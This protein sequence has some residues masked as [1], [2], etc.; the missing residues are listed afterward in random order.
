MNPRATKAKD[1]RKEFFPLRKK[2]CHGAGGL[3]GGQLGPR[4]AVVIARL[5]LA[6]SC[7]RRA[8]S[9]NPIA[10]SH[11]QEHTPG[12]A[13]TLAEHATKNATNPI[14]TPGLAQKSEP[15]TLKH[16]RCRRRLSRLHRHRGAGPG[17]GL[18]GFS[19]LFSLSARP[20]PNHRSH[21]CAPEAEYMQNPIEHVHLPRTHAKP[22]RTRSFDTATRPRAQ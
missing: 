21:L 19:S 1:E 12:V 11:A 7:A 4:L 17:A 2:Y 22:N 8:S 16:R 15:Q 10:R 5:S 3:R 14:E 20:V 9:S 18:C 13:R 6:C